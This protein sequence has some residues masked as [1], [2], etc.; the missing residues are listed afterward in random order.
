M[1]EKKENTPNNGSKD[2]QRP[3]K[4]ESNSVFGPVNRNGDLSKE[5]PWKDVTPPNNK[6]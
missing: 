4:N 1:S 2:P 3:Q 6:D 5:N